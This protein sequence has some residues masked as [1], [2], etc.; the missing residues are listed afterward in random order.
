MRLLIGLTILAVAAAPAMAQ[1]MNAETFHRRAMKLQSKGPAALFSMGEIKKL[2]A[3]GKAASQRARDIRL[4]AIA[5][6]KEPRYCPPDGPQSMKSSEFLSRLSAIP[7]SERAR[8]DMTEA[9]TRILERK[10]PC[11]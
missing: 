10:F 8:I 7:A 11:N 3:E 4:A 5:A 1:S 6:K 9:M 2:A